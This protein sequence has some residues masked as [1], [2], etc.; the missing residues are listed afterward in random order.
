[1]TSQSNFESFNYPQLLSTE[2]EVGSHEDTRRA[3]F[4]FRSAPL[5][6]FLIPGLLPEPNFKAPAMLKSATNRWII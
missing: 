5:K 1:M 3:A 2:K 4:I 6:T